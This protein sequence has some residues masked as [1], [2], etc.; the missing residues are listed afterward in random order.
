M[1]QPRIT[2]NDD[3]VSEGAFDRYY[4][5]DLGDAL[6]ATWEETMT[7]NPT[8]ALGRLIDSGDGGEMID[9]AAAQEKYGIGDLRFDEPV[10]EGR[11]QE[12]YDLKLA[13]IKRQEVLARGPNGVGAGIAKFSTA[14]LASVAD[15]INIASAFMPA[16]VARM[17]Y[18]AAGAAAPAWAV[19]RGGTLGSRIAGGAAEGMV[20]AAMIEPLPYFAAQRDQLDYDAFD[21]FMNVAFGGV[22]GGG[23]HGISRALELRGERRVQSQLEKTLEK[24]PDQQRQELHQAAVS[25]ALND[26]LPRNHGAAIAAQIDKD[27][28]KYMGELWAD[29]ELR[30][31]PQASPFDAGEMT[32]ARFKDY[33]AISEQDMRWME[34][35]VSDLEGSRGGNR[36]AL[37]AEGQGSTMDMQGVKTDSPAWFQD[38]NRTSSS[39]M[40]KEKARKVLEKMKG[41]QPLGKE[42]IRVAHTLW[43]AGRDMR[44]ANA[45]QIVDFRDARAAARQGEIEAEI[46]AIAAREAEFWEFDGSAGYRN[47]I[48]S[49]QDALQEIDLYVSPKGEQVALLSED[50]DRIIEGLKADL[51]AIGASGIYDDILEAA[52]LDVKQAE[53][54]ADGWRALGACMIRRG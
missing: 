41:Q 14:L 52:D 54:T 24:M 22:I 38:Y 3:Y 13:E 26:Q 50:A 11:A 35:A 19:G 34:G 33:S 1:I 32:G 46:D 36:W 44:E 45:R 49:D 9:P 27:R 25:D 40:T 47:D 31:P 28:V 12:L 48:F 4:R 5:P 2:W 39:T 17:G 15:P 29:A 18:R 21:S 6:G 37:E 53:V 42:E 7:H 16:T 43:A 51:D 20:G 8:N 23:A 30:K 10:S